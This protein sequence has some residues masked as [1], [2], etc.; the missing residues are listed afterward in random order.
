MQKTEVHDIARF[1]YVPLSIVDLVVSFPGSRSERS[2]PT[3]VK[4]EVQPCF[5]L[6][7]SVFVLH[8]DGAQTQ[9]ITV[10]AK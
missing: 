2:E 8:G 1:P 6:E 10:G 7:G 4:A 5:P 3:H 9:N